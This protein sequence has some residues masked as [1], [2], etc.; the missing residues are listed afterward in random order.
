LKADERLKT[1]IWES[2]IEQEDLLFE[3]LEPSVYQ[4]EIVFDE[5]P[6]GIWDSGN[7]LEHRQSEDKYTITLPELRANWVHEEIINIRNLTSQEV[8]VEVSEAAQDQ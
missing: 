6:N 2:S 7:Y 3:K 8:I 5:I 4:L 1:F